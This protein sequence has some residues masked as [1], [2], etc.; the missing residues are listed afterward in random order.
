LGDENGFGNVPTT[1]ELSQDENGY[2]LIRYEVA[3]D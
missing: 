3:K 2:N 1:I